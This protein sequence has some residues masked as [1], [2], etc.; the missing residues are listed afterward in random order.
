VAGVLLCATAI[1][2]GWWA[3]AR[4]VDR[5]GRVVARL[6]QGL[7]E[8]DGRLARVESRLARQRLGHEF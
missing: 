7:S 6:D 4:T 1:G 5:F 8:A 3:A 2:I